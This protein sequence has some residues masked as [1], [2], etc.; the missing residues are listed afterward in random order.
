MG[1]GGKSDT[2]GV[3]DK[4]DGTCRLD[5]HPRAPSPLAAKVARYANTH[6][7]HTPAEV[8]QHWRDVRVGG[9]EVGLVHVGGRNLSQLG[10]PKPN[11]L[12]RV[13]PSV[14]CV[15]FGGGVGV[16]TCRETLA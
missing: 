2:R 5:A 4:R 1:G 7:T 13:R 10:Q 11:K 6:S 16:S 14:S 12:Q 8:G 3:G 15:C 9:Q